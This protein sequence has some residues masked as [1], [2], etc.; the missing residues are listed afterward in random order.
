LTTFAQ[1]IKEDL[2]IKQYLNEKSSPSQIDSF[3]KS[4]SLHPSF[5][6]EGSL[7]KNFERDDLVVRRLNYKAFL[8]LESKQ[9]SS[10]QEDLRFQKW[11]F[12]VLVCSF[13]IDEDARR[14]VRGRK[15]SDCFD[16][17]LYYVEH[18]GDARYGLA[19]CGALYLKGKFEEEPKLVKTAIMGVESM[20][21]AGTI[22]SLMKLSFGRLRPYKNKGAFV[23]KGPYSKSYKSSFPSGHTTIA[24]ALASVIAEQSDSFWIKFISYGLASSVAFQRMYDDKHWLSDVVAGAIL[25]TFVGKKIV[26]MH[27]HKKKSCID[28][29]FIYRPSNK[30]AGLG[31]SFKF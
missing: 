6:F 28:I 1:D 24:F 7:K 15:Y 5:Y 11:L 17:Y 10:S 19:I 14:W 9:L 13:L 23:F 21:V 2:R 26:N 29:I 22:S 8:D 27:R 16:K 12:P 20:A 4:Y 3:Y 25:G 31:V 30:T 18:L